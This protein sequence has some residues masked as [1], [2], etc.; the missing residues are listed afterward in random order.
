MEYGGYSRS[1]YLNK[2]MIYV[3]GRKRWD[4]TFHHATCNSAQFKTYELFI[5]GISH[6]IFS[7]LS[8]PWITVT[9]KSKTT[10]KGELP[11]RIFNLCR[12]AQ[13]IMWKKVGKQVV[14]TIRAIKDY[15][16]TSRPSTPWWFPHGWVHVLIHCSLPPQHQWQSEFPVHSHLQNS[17]PAPG[18][19]HAPRDSCLTWN[20]AFGG[21]E[22]GVCPNARMAQN[23]RWT[24][25]LNSPMSSH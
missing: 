1:R 20:W 2:G 11:S 9:T 16:Q 4:V 14:L 8:W 17:E 24:C 15:A 21:R 25:L 12:N 3:L 7:D 5:S 23:R 6:L 19:Q 13:N 10:D 18:W 22:S